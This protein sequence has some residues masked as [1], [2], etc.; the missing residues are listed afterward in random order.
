MPTWIPAQAAVKTARAFSL[1]AFNAR[2][3]RPP[4]DQWPTIRHHELD[5]SPR[6]LPRMPR[7]C[8]RSR[9]SRLTPER[10]SCAFPNP[11]R[12]RA[13]GYTE[14]HTTGARKQWRKS[15]TVFRSA[16]QASAR[17][18]GWG[19]TRSKAL[20]GAGRH[21]TGLPRARYAVG[22]HRR[23]QGFSDTVQRPIRARGARHRG[24]EPSPH[25]HALRRRPQLP[26]DGAGG[27]RD[28]GRRAEA[29]SSAARS[30]A[31]LC[32]PDRRRARSGARA[33]HRP[34]RSEAGQRDD[35]RR[36][37][38]G[39]RFRAGEARSRRR[40]ARGNRG[41]SP[42]RTRGPRPGRWS[43]PS[44]TCRRSRPRP[45]TSTRA[46]TCSRSAWSCTRCCPAV[47]RSRANRRSPRSRPFCRRRPSRCA[48]IETGFPTA[49]SRSSG[50]A[51]RRSPRR[52]TRSAARSSRRWPR[53]DASSTTASFAVPRMALIAAG[54]AGARRSRSLRLAVVSARFARP[55]GGRDRR[56]ARS[57]G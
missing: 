2:D 24:H 15:A 43:A 30:G 44:P 46:P 53:S 7:F 42:Q 8:V 9:V 38:E 1:A 52:A 34:S 54:T 13:P 17:E 14:A 32:R 29:R 48:S 22:P 47:V 28:A 26:G 56:S 39:A 23:H 50:G 25:L 57:P 6:G 37:R 45:S 51:S 40:R 3:V 19:P 33:G 12:N 21:G 27:G 41:T 5:P 20:L 49:W 4:C 31:A 16:R 11:A 10:R 55:L 35:W 18:R 36:R